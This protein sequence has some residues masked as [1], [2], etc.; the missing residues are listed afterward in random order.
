MKWDAT[1]VE[2][3]ESL[4]DVIDNDIQHYPIDGAVCEYQGFHIQPS[5]AVSYIVQYDGHAG[6]V[7]HFRSSDY[8]NVLELVSDLND[9]VLKLREYN[10]QDDKEALVDWAGKIITSDESRAEENPEMY[11][12]APT[13]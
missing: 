13:A 2:N 8:D 12:H 3:G 1:D 5:T 4:H 7:M 9:R 11:V 6:S 10:Y